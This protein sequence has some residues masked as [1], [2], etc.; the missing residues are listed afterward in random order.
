MAEINNQQQAVIEDVIW[1]AIRTYNNKE[2]EISDYLK[3]K[4]LPHFIPMAYKE[5]ETREGHHRVLVPVIHNLLFV[6]RVLPQKE[7]AEVINNCRVPLRVMKKIDS[8][9]WYEISDKEMTD[10]RLICDPEYRGT[11]YVTQEEAETKIGKKVRITHGQFKGIEGKL[12]R[13]GK[14][15][16]IV[17]TL[18]GIGVLLHIPRWYCQEIQEEK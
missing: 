16:Y 3:E 13:Y 8:N 6:E 10:F 2:R 12:T 4:D 9:E 17:K 5:Q 14:E 7:M 11:R 1:Y 15:Y 18:A